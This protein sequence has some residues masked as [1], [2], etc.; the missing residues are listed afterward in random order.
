MKFQDYYEILGVGRNAS[1]DEIKK[2]YRRLALKWHPD[3]HRDNKAA[4]EEQ[5]K[6]MSEAYEVL[7]DPEKRKKYDRV[8]Q[9]FQQGQ[10][11]QPPAGG[12]SMSAEEFGALFGGRGFSDF[13]G[14]LFGEEIRGGAQGRARHR[15]FHSRGADVRAELALTIGDAIRRG[16]RNFTLAASA[17]CAE[18]GGV[19]QREHHVCPRCGGLGHVRVDRAVELKIPERAR[20]GMT[21][22]LAGLGEAGE[23]GADAGDLFLTIRLE[24][25]AV[26]RKCGADIEAAVPISLR[27]W[28]DGATVDVETLAGVAAVKVPPRFGFATRLRL[29]GLGL[30][31]EDGGRGEFW[32]APVLA[33]PEQPEPKLLAHLRQAAEARA[34]AVQGGARREG[35][36]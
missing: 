15:R 18:C 8:G 4:A 5:F 32:V 7:F 10:E 36:R 2:A 22:R 19:G 31:R 35:S 23:S 30:T 1:P 3:R 20:D 24:S 29:R 33:L 21:L 26:Y 34:A 16:T 13:F 25:D 17:V 28:L 27:E 11:F 12:G 9:D 6:R 14:S